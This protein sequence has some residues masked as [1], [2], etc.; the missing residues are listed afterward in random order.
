MSISPPACFTLGRHARRQR[1]AQT[2]SAPEDTL[3]HWEQSREAYR[4]VLAARPKDKMAAHNLKVVELK[5]AKLHAQLAQRLLKE[6]E[7]KPLQ[8]SIE[9]LQAALDHQRTAQD[10]D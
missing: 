6:A 10:L 2:K 3:P 8:P 4:I 7:K 9:K 1:V 5:L